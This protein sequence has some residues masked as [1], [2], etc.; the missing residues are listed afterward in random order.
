M[1]FAL[2][3]TFAWI[4]YTLLYRKLNK[5]NFSIENSILPLMIFSILVTFDLGINY[6]AGAILSLN[7]GIAIHGLLSRLI[8]GEDGWSVDLFKNYY[9][10]SFFISCSLTFIFAIIKIIPIKPNR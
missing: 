6:L 2:T 1:V 5:Q 3:V 9:R 4:C 8:I 7:D 10:A